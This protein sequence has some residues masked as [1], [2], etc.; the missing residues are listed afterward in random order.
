MTTKIQWTDETWLMWPGCVPASAGCANCYAVR[1]GWRLAYN[2][3]P[4][5]AAPYAGIVKKVLAD[6]T[7]ILGG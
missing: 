3:N 1:D 2:P 5:V 4:K 7:D 6:G